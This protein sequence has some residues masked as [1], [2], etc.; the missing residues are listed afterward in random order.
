MVHFAED[1]YLTALCLGPE[2]DQLITL[3]H[4][5]ESDASFLKMTTG[6]QRRHFTE[7]SPSWDILQTNPSTD[8]L[9]HCDTLH[10]LPFTTGTA[11]TFI[12]G[13]KETSLWMELRCEVSP[14]DRAF[15]SQMDIPGRIYDKFGGF[16]A[17]DAN[18]YRV[19]GRAAAGGVII[20]EAMKI[21]P[22]LEGVEPQWTGA[23]HVEL[24][25]QD[26]YA[27]PGAAVELRVSFGVVRPVRLLAAYT[28]G[29]SS[30]SVAGC[31]TPKGTR[32]I[33]L[34]EDASSERPENYT[35]RYSG[36]KAIYSIKLL[37]DSQC[38]HRFKS[39]HP[40]GSWIAEAI[41]NDVC[42]L[43]SPEEDTIK[44]RAAAI[45][46]GLPK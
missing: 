1:E 43:L 29:Y 2:P 24:F 35:F 44:R 19:R 25:E 33:V 41:E 27:R 38:S 31:L 10:T 13:Q 30:F 45:R 40:D 39:F 20:R 7:C 4:K 9:R 37:G 46:L 11:P 8:L 23:S 16:A 5:K 28:D 32:F 26:F 17:S 6:Y 18:A 3:V 12:V 22:T 36:K 15:P 21:P 34:C 42:I 14:P